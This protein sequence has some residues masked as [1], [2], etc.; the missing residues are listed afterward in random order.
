M[1]N[2]YYHKQSF[3]RT[4]NQTGQL[5]LTEWKKTWWSLTTGSMITL[6]CRFFVEYSSKNIERNM[7]NLSEI[8]AVC[9][10]DKDVELDYQKSEM[11]TPTYFVLSIYVLRCFMVFDR[12]PR[13][14]LC[15]ILVVFILF[16]KWIREKRVVFGWERR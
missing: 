3:F 2:L 6:V 15:F 1:S 11:C 8:G 16:F 9:F 14:F 7:I 12:Y 5:F 10:L 4:L 13:C